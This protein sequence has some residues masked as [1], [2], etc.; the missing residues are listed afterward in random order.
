MYGY[1][2]NNP[3]FQ[4][5]GHQ[6]LRPSP[7]DGMNG[8]SSSAIVRSRTSSP[9]PMVLRAGTPTDYLSSTPPFSQGLA[10]AAAARA[11]RSG[12]PDS[13]GTPG[14]AAS[15]RRAGLLR[16]QQQQ[17]GGGSGR[18]ARPSPAGV[19]MPDKSPPF[20]NPMSLQAPPTPDSARPFPSSQDSSPR[21]I[22]SSDLVTAAPPAQLHIPDPGEKSG[23]NS[24]LN[25]LSSLDMLRT[26]PFQGVR[27]VN[28]SFC[29]FSATW[30]GTQPTNK[31]K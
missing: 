22:K 14:T 25:P 5:T 11:G 31:R 21:Q 1:G 20:V 26:S 18:F 8:G 4:A 2:Y 28:G 27:L 30:V 29:V 17:Q 12:A 13:P 23:S 15:L 16:T 9:S 3:D 24:L 7:P 10:M 19:G 6:S